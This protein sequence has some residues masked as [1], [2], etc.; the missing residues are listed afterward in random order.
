MN[1]YLLILLMGVVAH[2]GEIGQSAATLE[3]NNWLTA[4]DIRF[5][6]EVKLFLFLPD[7]VPIDPSSGL[8]LPSGQYR[9][10]S[11]DRLRGWTNKI[12]R[13]L[14]VEQNGHPHY[15]VYH[16]ETTLAFDLT[17]KK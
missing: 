14:H 5:T 4:R 17:G 3:W 11:P 10:S 12:I 15:W 6:E 16:I 2:A 7:A 1:K 9:T 8:L 13:R